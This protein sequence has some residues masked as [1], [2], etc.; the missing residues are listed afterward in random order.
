MVDPVLTRFAAERIVGLTLKGQDPVVEL[1]KNASA[2]SRWRL[3]APIQQQADDDKVSTLL[4][5]LG[6]LPVSD[7]V[8][9]VSNAET[10]A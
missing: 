3:E 6:A 8:L 7:V 5:T 1:K 4:T 9:D 10:T 2:G